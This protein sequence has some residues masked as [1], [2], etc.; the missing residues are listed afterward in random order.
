MDKNFS[1]TYSSAQQEEIKHIRDKYLPAEQ[2][3]QMERLRQLDRSVTRPGMIAALVIG[4]ISALILGTGMCFVMLWPDTL[5]APGIALGI[6]GLIGVSTA[7]PVYL[8]I[9]KKR[10]NQL[11]PEITRLSNELL[12]GQ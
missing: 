12:I 7:D 5:F 11:A 10:R 9:T 3:D 8:R 4:I 1:Y 2:E 6:F